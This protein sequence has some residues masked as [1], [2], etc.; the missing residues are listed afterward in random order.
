MIRIHGLAAILALCATAATQTTVLTTGSV[1]GDFTRVGTTVGLKYVDKDTT[2]GA[3]TQI[4]STQS[5]AMALTTIG[6]Q[7]NLTGKGMETYHLVDVL[8][9]GQVVGLDQHA[10]LA[11]GTTQSSDPRNVTP[12]AQVLDWA[13]PGKKDDKGVLRVIW[14]ATATKGA[15][16]IQ[17]AVD[18]DGDA[19]SDWTGGVTDK[20]VKE[21]PVVAGERGFRI[22]IKVAGDA[23]VKGKAEALY[24]GHLT[25][26]FVPG[27]STG[28][29]WDCKVESFGTGCGPTLQAKVTTEGTG[30]RV[31][32]YFESLTTG[33]PPSSFGL[34]LTGLRKLSAPLPGSPKC[35]LLVDPF[36]IFVLPS[37]KDG[38]ATLKLPFPP[39][40]GMVLHMQ[41]VWV[42]VKFQQLV[43]SS[44]NGVTLSCKKV[45][46]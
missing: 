10:D 43:L 5:G 17:A 14:F 1:V 31:Q 16:S 46:G 45:G 22:Q 29:G 19:K 33:A 25:L 12:G 38:T 36:N 39:S 11:A 27:A 8:T 44:T 2:L 13:I 26:E 32:H 7:D 28:S 6:H 4:Q 23:A 9:G 18:V 15:A 20:E 41:Q 30:G 3:K 35:L 40:D 42:A 37:G 21:L 24:K 34:H